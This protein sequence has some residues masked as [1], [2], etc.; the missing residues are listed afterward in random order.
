[1]SISPDEGDFKGMNKSTSIVTLLL[2]AA[3]LFASSFTI[4][5]QAGRR[6]TV[7]TSV[8][9]PARS[10]GIEALYLQGTRELNTGQHA[11]ALATFDKIIELD[12]RFVEAHLARG[13][14]L[15]KMG[16]TREAVEALK[17]ALALAPTNARAHYELGTLYRTLNEHSSAIAAFKQATELEPTNARGFYELA[18][19]YLRLGEAGAA[20]T[21]FLRTV[22]TDRAFTDADA[23]LL[24]LLEADATR[25]ATG[26]ALASAVSARLLSAPAR[27]YFALALHFAGRRREARKQAEVLEKLDPTL[28][29][30]LKQKIGLP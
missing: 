18:D 21:A 4:H 27:Y 15:I 17:Q 16:R 10:G 23:A 14:T 6:R 3:F 20:A 19:I 24:K 30:T 8:S 28:F 29:A 25:G 13:R 9:A 5:G 2:A 11:A 7:D 26:A 1:L 22:E 12:P